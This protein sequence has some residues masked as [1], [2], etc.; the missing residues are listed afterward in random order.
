MSDISIEDIEK[1]REDLDK[2]D[3]PDIKVT[4][5]Y[6]PRIGWVNKEEYVPDEE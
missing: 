6:Q 1:A 5:V 2:Q 4:H 3:I